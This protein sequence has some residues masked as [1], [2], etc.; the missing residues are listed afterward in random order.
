MLPLPAM[1]ANSPAS[2]AAGHR[3]WTIAALLTA[4]LIAAPGAASVDRWSIDPAQTHI[5]F[6]ID[7]IGLP[8]TQ[9]EF[10][11]FD[12]R[13]AIDFEHPALS[14]VSFHVQAQSIDAGS[15]LLSDVLR[16]G[17]FF[18]AA[19]FAEIDFVSK[20]IEK[21]DEQQVRVGGELTM[22]G[23]TQPL[24]VDVAVRPQP[25]KPRAHRLHC[26][27]DHRSAGIWNDDRLSRRFPRR[28]AHRRK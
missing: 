10:R 25:A 22:H 24:T 11:S 20:T 3:R 8:R 7:A 1:H 26:E 5:S 23:V 9:G 27:G 15:P 2:C 12:G 18:D 28:R 6:S 13:I 17:A 16:S 21:I 19:R 4:V 14:G